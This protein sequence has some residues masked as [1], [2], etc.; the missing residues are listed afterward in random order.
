MESEVEEMLIA[1]RDVEFPELCAAISAHE[2]K[3]K[4]CN[5]VFLRSCL[6]ENVVQFTR[7]I[8]IGLGS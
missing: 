4:V 5:H 2:L 1:N 7:I 6:Y 3:E 8:S